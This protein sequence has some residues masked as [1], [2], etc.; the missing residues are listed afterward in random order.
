M[1]IHR[2]SRAA[3]FAASFVFGLALAQAQV[4]PPSARGEKRPPP[5]PTATMGSQ[6]IPAGADAGTPATSKGADIGITTN[7]R[8]REEM[9]GIKGESAAARAAARKTGGGISAVDDA[10]ASG[11]TSGKVTPPKL[12]AA[13]TVAPPPKRAASSPVPPPKPSPP[14]R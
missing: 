4:L 1:K 12:T 5:P 8:N 9:R 2:P 14:A 3:P 11:P 6:Q 13:G 7:A 10:I